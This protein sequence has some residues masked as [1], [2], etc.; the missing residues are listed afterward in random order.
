MTSTKY[1]SVLYRHMIYRCS[2][3]T[4][5][6]NLTDMAVTNVGSPEIF[7]TQLMVPNSNRMGEKVTSGL[8]DQ[9]FLQH[10]QQNIAEYTNV[11]PCRADLL[12]INNFKKSNVN[13]L[14]QPQ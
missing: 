2:L 4:K 8:L 11:F 10:L 7:N 9:E 1:V 5:F 12:I 3:L 6:A 13:S 14:A